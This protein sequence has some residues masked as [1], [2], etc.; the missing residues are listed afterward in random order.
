MTII[1]GRSRRSLTAVALIVVAASGWKLVD[2]PAVQAN[3][4]YFNLASGSFSQNW[5]DTNLIDAEDNWDA[6][7]SII[8]FRGDDLTTAT[9]ANPQT[10]TGTSTVV[11]V[12]P[13][14]TDP[15]TFITGGVAEFEL[16]DPTIALQGSGT[17]DA[18]YI[19]LHLNSTGRKNITVSYRL[20][21]LDTNADN[22]AQQL[23]LQF[24]P[25]PSGAWINIPEGYVPD[26]TAGPNV[27][28][29]DINRTVTLPAGAND[30]V[31]LQVRFITTNAGGSDEWVGIDDIVVTSEP[32][33]GA[34]PVAPPPVLTRISEIQG[35]GRISPKLDQVVTTQG[36]VTAR[37]RNGFYLQSDVPDSNELT[38]EGIFVFT[39]STPDAMASIG[40]TIKVSGRVAEFSNLSEAAPSLT[41]ITSPFGLEVISAGTTANLPASTALTEADLAPTAGFDRLERYEGML[42]TIPATVVVA[43]TGERAPNADGQ[44]YVTLPKLPAPFRE[45]GLEA[46]TQLASNEPPLPNP[47]P[48]TVPRFDSNPEVLRVDTDELF[49]YDNIRTPGITAVVGAKV[50]AF[51]AVLHF[52]DRTYNA[53]PV[54]ANANSVLGLLSNN[55]LQPVTAVPRPKG[56]QF[57]LSSANLEFFS[58]SD[59]ARLAKVVRAVC[60]TLRAPDILGVIEIDSLASLNAIAN[61]VNTFGGGCAGSQYAAFLTDPDT[62]DQNTGF[63]V[64]TTVANGTRVAVLEVARA[65]AIEGGLDPAV[66]FT[67]GDR[68]PYVLRA[69]VS[70]NGQTLPLAVVLNHP[71]S[72][73]GADLSTGD[74]DRQKRLNHALYAANLV[75]RLQ[76]ENPNGNLA[77]MGDLNAFE[78]NDGLV[79]VTGILRGDPVPDAQTYVAGDSIDVFGTPNF[80]DLVDLTLLP[81]FSPQERYS[82]T[83]HG[84]RQVLDHILVNRN[85]YSLVRG[86]AI[87]HLNSVY[88]ALDPVSGAR[89][90]EMTTRP[91]GYSDHDVPAAYF[92]L[93]GGANITDRLRVTSSGLIYNRATGIYS[94]TLTIR[95]TS[96]MSLTGPFSVVLTNVSAGVTFEDE[97]GISA[98]GPILSADVATLSP[99]QSVNV[100]YQLRNSSTTPPSF[101]TQVYS[102]DY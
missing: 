48:A 97:T 85:L 17:A 18:P 33:N 58:A 37:A 95:N 71:K 5:S 7:P 11:D 91:E 51:T 53:L 100:P 81:E 19:Q 28:G 23:A 83:F 67:S 31:Q 78:F 15:N 96:G 9:D 63:L 84:D 36:I 93:R 40:S 16:S 59:T 45:P 70:G 74:A 8:G 73:I 24:R 13:N 32:C 50:A 61:G 20:R 82:Y 87:A 44:F 80:A 47:A 38:S 27:A 25:V 35:P 66:I 34:C 64:K 26:A 21:D 49:A 68:R 62:S 43:P 86:Y 57:T 10:I 94:G 52:E 29:P 22:A 77:L 99:G 60:D 89:L 88:P 69:T 76:T 75:R 41:E 65:R 14:R 90:R 72:L 98:A 12:N 30:S 54:V 42:V 101:E 3:S 39:S 6:V 2:L 55:V 102:G 4:L 56:N 79:D 46:G 1:R 92:A